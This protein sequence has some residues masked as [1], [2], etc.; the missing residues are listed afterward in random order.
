MNFN[1][2]HLNESPNFM[3]PKLLVARPIFQSVIDALAQTFEVTS[4]QSDTPWTPESWQQA[5]SLHDAALTTG[6]DPINASVLGSQP[7]RPMS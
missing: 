1:F 7:I 3:K 2:L 6:S 4:N 5:I